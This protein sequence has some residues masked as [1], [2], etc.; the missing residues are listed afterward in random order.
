MRTLFVSTQK[1]IKIILE[2]LISKPLALIVYWCS[3]FQSV[4]G[5]SA[6]LEHGFGDLDL[7]RHYRASVRSG[8]DV[9]QWRSGAQSVFRFIP[10]MLDWTHLTISLL[11][12]QGH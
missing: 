12:V 3:S 9:G 4:G 11:Y 6:I 5:L 2:H 7:F 10:K 8:A 1:H